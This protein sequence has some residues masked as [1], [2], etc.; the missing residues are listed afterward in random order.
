MCGRYFLT[1]PGEVLA[2]IFETGSATET[3]ALTPRYNIAPTQQVPIVRL[4]A[5][6]R[7]EMA[8]ASW[9]LV[10]VWAKEKAIGNKLINARAETLAEKPSFRDAYRKRRCVLPA[11][12][13]FEWKREGAV[14]Q[15]YAFRARDGRPLALAGLWSFWKEPATGEPLESC[16]I[17]T[18]SP[19][20]LAATVHDRMPAI[21]SPDGIARWLDGATPATDLAALFEPFPAEAMVA[22]PVS[23]RVNSPANDSADLLEEM[24]S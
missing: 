23:R 11:D 4:G 22:Y 10:P 5:D 7:R 24:P 12:G 1:T 8:L 13:Y 2:D 16:A 21:L 19:N 17:V 20:A 15:P 18:T 3:P 9:G 6:G 14:K